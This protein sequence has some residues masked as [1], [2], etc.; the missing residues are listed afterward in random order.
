MVQM[1]EWCKNKS[2]WND[3]KRLTRTHKTG[4]EREQRLTNPQN[5]HER[6]MLQTRTDTKPLNNC[7]GVPSW[8]RL[9]QTP[10]IQMWIKQIQKMDR[11]MHFS[12]A[13]FFS[14]ISFMCSCFCLILVFLAF[15][16]LQ[17]SLVQSFWISYIWS[18]REWE[19]CFLNCIRFFMM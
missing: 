6:K 11:W 19:L 4:T 15:G 9:Q 17:R 7:K 8:D 3:L 16:R 12:I 1:Q 10:G 13:A 18:L 5:K 14:C 2:T